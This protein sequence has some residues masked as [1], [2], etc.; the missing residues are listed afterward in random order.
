M[1]KAINPIHIFCCFILLMS[2][3]KNN[4]INVYISEYQTF[5]DTISHKNKHTWSFESDSI[6]SAKR[7]FYTTMIGKLN[8]VDKAGLSE[9]DIINRDLLLLEME[10]ELNDINFENYLLPLNSEGGFLA[11]IVYDIQY[12]T[13][14]SD[15]DKKAYIDKL[16]NL[17]HY[18]SQQKG[19]L[20]IGIQ[21]NKTSPKVIT[22]RCI[23]FLKPYFS[24]PEDDN[25]FVYPGS[26]NDSLLA[27]AKIIVKDK[28]VPAYLDFYNFLENEYL[29]ASTVAPGISGLA[30]G[31]SFYENKTK[32]FTTLDMTPDEVFNTGM[33]EVDRIKKEMMDV[34]KESGFRGTFESFLEFLRKDPQFY[35]KTPKELLYRATWLS[36]KI[37]GKLPQYFNTLPRM[38][39][40]VEEV[41][42]SI[43][44]NYTGGR[45][46]EGSYATG[47]PGA[48]WVNTYKLESRP[49]YV[50]PALTLHEAVPGHHLQI[51]LSRELKNVPRF[52]ENLYISAFGEGWGL[53]SEFLGIEAGMYE[54]P[55]EN[56]GRL[57]YE[58]WRACRL[59][60]DAGIHY[61]GWTRD[62]A[63]SFMA[64][65]TAL[66]LHEVNTEIDRYIGWPAQAVSYKIGE[67]KIRELRKKAEKTLGNKFDIKAFHDMVLSKGSIKLST[68]ETMVET[69]ISSVK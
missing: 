27:V 51:M 16:Q 22:Q 11:G 65:N 59:V 28:I 36:K 5:V 46:S 17:P 49:L 15:E 4:D 26:G 14:K 45:Y 9:D 63:V 13:I 55:F 37:E 57:T 34:M 62:Q 31:K 30:G 56:F 7:T 48:Y 32:Y 10:N 12:A 42:A 61:K 1:F 43:A 69:W 41:P 23:D 8:A 58:M 40:T 44:P 2:C 18:L 67:I 33:K 20:K 39:F 50:L 68:L 29:P 54:T 35:A 47:K 19:V 52:R 3:K 25:V 24:L 38:P 64:G 60:V 21:K 6:R 66:S 53:Y